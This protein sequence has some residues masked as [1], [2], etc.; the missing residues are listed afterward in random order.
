[1][2]KRILDLINSGMDAVI[3]I[4]SDISAKIKNKKI[5]QQKMLMI[6]QAQYI[7]QNMQR[8]IFE[9]MHQNHYANVQ[10]I[11]VPSNIRP[12]RFK[13]NV[14]KGII[15]YYTVTKINGDAIAPAVLNVLLSNI[16]TDIASVSSTLYATWGAYGF[17][18]NYPYLSAGLYAVDIRDMG[19]D[20]EIG[21]QTHFK[22]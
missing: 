10:A 11:N 9:V 13:Y 21:F 19:T 7:Q 15:Y 2:K 6:Q 18:C 17:Q 20:I 16:N 5:A 4:C 12:L 3:N 22:W 14:K 1:M 8:D